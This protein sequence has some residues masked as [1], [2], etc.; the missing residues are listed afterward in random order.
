MQLMHA[1]IHCHYVTTGTAP[2]FVWGA[3][4]PNFS[5][6]NLCDASEIAFIS[7]DYFSKKHWESVSLALCVQSSL[8]I[9]IEQK[10][11]TCQIK[12]LRLSLE[13]GG[14]VNHERSLDRRWLRYSL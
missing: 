1:S 14:G 10:G 4:Y 3:A 7:S 6:S 12:Q 9:P 13:S 8:S 11:H 2:A 5:T